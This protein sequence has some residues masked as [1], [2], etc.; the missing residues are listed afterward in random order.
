[1]NMLTSTL[2]V[3][4]PALT[5]V[6]FD[7]V[8]NAFSFCI[9]ALAAAA[10]FF[11]NARAQVGEKYRPALLISGLVVSIAA[12]HY[13]RIFNAWDG[14][15]SLQDGIY[16][17]TG[18]PFN[19]AYRYADWLLTVPLLLVETVAVLA[20]SPKVSRSMLL[21]LAAAAVVMVVTGYPGEISD[22]ITVRLIWG[23]I[24]TIP[25]AYILYVLWVELGKA[26]ERQPQEVKSLVKSLRL[27]LLLSWG[28][29][30]IAYLLP[31][32][33]IAGASATVG[34]QMGY[35]IADVLAKPIFGLYIFAIAKAKTEADRQKV[36]L[37]GV[38]TTQ[39]RLKTAVN[40]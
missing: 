6:Q 28:V 15:Y 5:P 26:L 36:E 12:Y 11:F 3:I 21:R 23:T 37:D 27:L 38:S 2:G 10:L 33:G 24:S 20:L 35:T 29:Y 30:P 18:I 1:M 31:A 16:A 32:L 25:F 9:A 17:A 13:F 14:A 39:T 40:N 22:S 7:L 4:P 19:D 34:L 8:Y